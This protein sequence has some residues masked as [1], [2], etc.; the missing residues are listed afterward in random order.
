MTIECSPQNRSGANIVALASSAET[1]TTAAAP[2]RPRPS[3]TT[4]RSEYPAKTATPSNRAQIANAIPAQGG[5]R[6]S[7]A[8]QREDAR[9]ERRAGGEVDEARREFVDHGPSGLDRRDLERG[10]DQPDHGR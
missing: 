7:R 9:G 2:I 5:R 4:G 1:A 3:D 10:C 6:P 8:G